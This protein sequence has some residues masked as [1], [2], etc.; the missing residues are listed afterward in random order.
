MAFR[1]W[2][3]FSPRLFFV[4]SSRDIWFCL[5]VY[6]AAISDVSKRESVRFYAIYCPVR[7]PW[8]HKS[9]PSPHPAGK[10]QLIQTYI[11][12]NPR[13]V[14]RMTETWTKVKY[15]N[16]DINHRIIVRSA[17]D[18]R[19]MQRHKRRIKIPSGSKLYRNYNLRSMHFLLL[20]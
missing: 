14:P 13:Y 4:L 12:I 16:P 2:Y 1:N 19:R 3:P 6:L 11:H 20:I 8:T 18:R 5:T 17:A 15:C 10:L 9:R 7:N